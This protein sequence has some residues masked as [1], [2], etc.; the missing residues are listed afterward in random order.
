MF[1]AR[2]KYQQTG[3]DASVLF[4]LAFFKYLE[5]KISGVPIAVVAAQLTGLK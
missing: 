3:S 2:M 4:E 1:E 5:R